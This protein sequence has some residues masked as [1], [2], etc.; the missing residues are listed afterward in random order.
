MISMPDELLVK[1][2]RQARKAGTTRSGWLREI[3]EHA[4]E[5]DAEARAE[6]IR[7]FLA[8]ARPWGEGDSA[9]WVRADRDR[10]N[11]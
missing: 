8:R 7:E 3:A 4:I 1:V 2:D 5:N 6:R 9:A 10:D 11:P